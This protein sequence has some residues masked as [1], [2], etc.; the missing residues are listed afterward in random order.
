MALHQFGQEVQRT[1]QIIKHGIDAGLIVK[2]GG[3][4]FPKL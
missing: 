4:D 1:R 2:P 3:V